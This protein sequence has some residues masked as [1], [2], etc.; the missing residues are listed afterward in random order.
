MITPSIADHPH[1]R[2]SLRAAADDDIRRQRRLI[3]IIGVARCRPCN[4]HNDNTIIPPV[5]ATCE[6][7]R[8]GLRGLAANLAGIRGS[9]DYF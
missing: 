4:A 1:R 7:R 9:R 3:D 6:F 5:V 8:R 2:H